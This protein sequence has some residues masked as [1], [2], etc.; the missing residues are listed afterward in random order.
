MRKKHTIFLSFLALA[1]TLALSFSVVQLSFVSYADE[2]QTQIEEKPAD[3]DPPPATSSTTKATTES[4][5]I[6]PIDTTTKK[7]PESST[8]ISDVISSVLNSTSAT[9]STTT[10]NP[11]TSEKENPAVSEKSSEKESSATTANNSTSTT[12]NSG[13]N[14]TTTRNSRGTTKYVPV[15][16]ATTVKKMSVPHVDNTEISGSTLSPM[17]AYFERISGDTT[18]EPF[19]LYAEETELATTESSGRNLS[20]AAIVAICLVAIAAV[21]C[22]LTLLFAIRNKRANSVDDRPVEYDDEYEDTYA[23]SDDAS[24][25]AY[26]GNTDSAASTVDESSQFTVVSLD[27]KDYKD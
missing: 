3:D 6:S 27:D 9:S 16:P 14:K 4:T 24:G 21:V 26:Y 25:D 23:D 15:A 18:T 7:P 13:G 1:L 8:K 22:L 2:V 5:S 11:G 10:E 17:D 12:K 19:S 20:T